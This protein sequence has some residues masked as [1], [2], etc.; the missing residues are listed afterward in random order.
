MENKQK[1]NIGELGK[2]ISELSSRLKFLDAQKENKYQEL[3]KVNFALNSLLKQAS[4]LKKNKI[5]LSAQI[6]TKKEERD[7]FNREVSELARQLKEIGTTDV[8]DRIKSLFRFKRRK[9]LDSEILKSQIEQL[10]MKLQTEVLS[11]GKEQKLMVQIKELRERIKRAEKE[12][13]KLREYNR[14]RGA[15]RKSKLAADA[16]HK[17]IQS[18]AASNS[19]FF[20]ELSEVSRKIALLKDKRE[21]TKKEIS[22]FKVELSV[23]NKALGSKLAVFSEAKKRVVTATQ[24]AQEKVLAKKAEV[25]KKKL[26]DRKKLT[27]EDILAM[28]RSSMGK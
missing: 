28:Q 1:N 5:K 17:E 26:K 27:T 18:V 22:G 10:N 14:I 12:D 4:E 25:A 15:L 13:L 3:S 21:S 16:V 8:L 11:Y 9:P 7:K 19:K 24:A 6:R 23:L 2:N 20:N